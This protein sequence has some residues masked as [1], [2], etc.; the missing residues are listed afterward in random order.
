MCGQWEM[1]T[2]ACQAG[3]TCE[4]VL[5]K[6]TSTKLSVRFESDLSSSAN[7]LLECTSL[8]MGTAIAAMRLHPR[9]ETKICLPI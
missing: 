4:Q 5:R 3:L 9:Q 6:R 7:R 8:D 2:K 1:L